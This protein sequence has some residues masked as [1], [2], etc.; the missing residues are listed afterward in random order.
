[1]KKSRREGGANV[2][3]DPGSSSRNSVSGSVSLRESLPHTQSLDNR[4]TDPS[5][6]NCFS[7]SKFKTKRK[8]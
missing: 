5:V 8:T 4:Q 2:Q 6:T 3:Q 7:K 1:M